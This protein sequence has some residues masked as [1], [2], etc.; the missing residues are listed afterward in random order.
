MHK[1]A[2]APYRPP[3]CRIHSDF[4]V[5]FTPTECSLQA[6]ASSSPA[7]HPAQTASARSEPACLCLDPT[8][9]GLAYKHSFTSWRVGVP[10]HR[11]SVQLRDFHVSSFSLVHRVPPS[12]GCFLASAAS[13]GRDSANFPSSLASSIQQIPLWR[14]LN[15]SRPQLLF[16]LVR[17]SPGC[18][19]RGAC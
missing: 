19:Q 11:P 12:H 1:Q 10:N 9:E 16:V 13:V 17:S 18:C 15:S 6:E 4:S 2:T 3:S 7:S 8:A 5:H 14:V